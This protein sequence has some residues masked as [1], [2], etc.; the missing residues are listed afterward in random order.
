MKIKSNL[1]DSES[2]SGKLID[3]LDE[4]IKILFEN[5]EKSEK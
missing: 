1:Y 3:Y 2:I 5:Y 4:G